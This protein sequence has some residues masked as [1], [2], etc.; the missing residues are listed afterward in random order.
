MIV[1]TNPGAGR[2]RT[3]PG[4][5]LAL[6]ALI[7]LGATRAAAEPARRSLEGTA[8]LAG[9]RGSG[10][11]FHDDYVSLQQQL[12]DG[13]RLCARVQ[14]PV[15]FD[16]RTGAILELP[17]GSSV[18]IETRELQKGS[19]RMLITEEDGEPRYEWWLNGTARP[20]DGAA[21]A[22]LADAL[23][24]VSAFRAIGSIQGEVGDLQ[25]QIGSIQ[26]EIG[27]LQGQIGSIQGEEG[28]LQG[29]IGSIH[30]EVGSLQ[31]RI[32]SHQGA[33]ANLQAARGRAS[34]ATGQQLDRDIREHEAA[35]RKLE[36]EIDSGELSRRLA[37]AEAELR[38]FQ[39][40]SRGEIA[41]L[42][43]RIEA[44]R[45]QDGIAELK[46]Q[47]EELHAEDRIDEI[48]RRMAPALERLKDQIGRLGN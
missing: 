11:R 46:R 38:A 6:L 47:I 22:W 7:L 39:R 34:A 28:S 26:G 37:K 15:L 21:R 45:S 3:A 27:S 4:A 13:Q 44:I 33:I 16:E 40:S 43:R 25:G 5:S 19:Q 2:C 18:L 30:G 9:F 12:G 23:E 48:E 8:C 32:G 35:I 42:E 1:D 10:M 24:V 17:K 41:Q 36:D 29:K 14:G 31:G 20:V